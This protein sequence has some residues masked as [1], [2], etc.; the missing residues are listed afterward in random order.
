MLPCRN[1]L[2]YLS[3]SN[4]CNALSNDLQVLSL[5]VKIFLCRL[6][7][8][9]EVFSTH[10]FMPKDKSSNPNGLNVEFF[11]EAISDHPFNA[12]SPFFTTA[13]LPRSLC[14][15]VSQKRYLKQKF[16]ISYLFLSAICPISLFPKSSLIAL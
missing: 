2:S 10:R 15:F 13:S 8:K 12:I 4:I 9:H 16:F 14:C 3:N 5:K 6:V 7:T 11:W 1:L